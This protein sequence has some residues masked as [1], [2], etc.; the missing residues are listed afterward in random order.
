[1]E[2]GRR[3]GVLASCVAL[4]WL[5]S[6]PCLF[7]SH[8]WARA[9]GGTGT[10][11]A[12]SVQATSDGG[13]ILAGRTEDS[14]GADQDVWLVKLDASGSVS[15]QRTFAGAAGTDSAYSVR[16]TA[17]GGYYLG[18]NTQTVG[19]GNDAWI[20]R[21]DSAGSVIWQKTYGGASDDWLFSLELT[22]DGGCV[23]G[24]ST[25]SFGAA[26]INSWAVKLG[27][28]GV[29]AWAKRRYVDEAEW[30]ASVAPDG[31]GGYG[32]LAG[33][34]GNGGSKDV[35]FMRADSSGNFINNTKHVIG[36]TG[37]EDPKRLD[38]L[39]DGSWMVSGYVDWPGD[40]YDGF[41]MK[42]SSTGSPVWQ[43]QVG[44]A[45]DDRFFSG[46][47]TSDG[48]YAAVG[49]TV[50][51]SD[52]SYDLWVVKL[53]SAGRAVWQKVYG[54]AGDEFGIDIRELRD[55]GFIVVGRSTS[56]GNASEVFALRLSSNGDIDTSCGALVESVSL[57]SADLGVTDDTGFTSWVANTTVTVAT[58]VYAT[59]NTNGTNTTLCVSSCQVS[60]SASVP[61][62]GVVGMAASFAC[63]ASLI[64]CGGGVVSYLW[65]FG[66]GA[67]STEQNPSHVYA[68]AGQIPWSLTVSA[69]GASSCVQSG[70]ISVSATAE[71]DLTGTWASVTKKKSKVNAT[72]SCQ[73]ANLGD[74][75]SF[76][77]KIYFSKKASVSKKSTL[78]KTQ[79]VSTLAAGGTAPIKIKATPT[80][81]HKYIVAV[82]DTP[83]TVAESNEVNNLIARALP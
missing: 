26:G 27:S 53:D 66:D 62:S 7:A 57:S 73:N 46:R 11:S 23:F 79:A 54:G 42:L 44:G 75:G 48:G 43:K 15:W 35:W 69:S 31:G 56:Y 63:S 22:G 28:D 20:L 60:C 9:I 80:S 81:K 6:S 30:I 19:N 3:F 33:A 12:S 10:E 38:R 50:S 59:N 82:I 51:P 25:S 32:L 29:V 40:N 18:C 36:S 13:Y 78:I 39:G 21:L 24:G 47:P 34:S 77:V 37:F 70:T 16:Q 41:L 72:L 67:T 83:S 58:P 14:F 8:Q 61:A 1:M 4:I 65:D 2:L 74:A 71:P 64:D 17:D 55:G 68:A 52:G 5:D 49:F 76:T 45:G